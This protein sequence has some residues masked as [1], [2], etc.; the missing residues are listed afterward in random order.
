MFKLQANPTFKAVVAIT[1]AGDD[2]PGL[3]EFEFNNLRRKEFDALWAEVREEKI[4][5]LDAVMKIVKTWNTQHPEHGVDAAF[6]REAMDEL[7][8]MFP[9]AASEIVVAFRK[10]Q[11]ES[12]RKN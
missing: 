10:A 4:T 5:E 12:K 2:K 9:A 3:I 1:R 8:D 11:N 6:T 7:I